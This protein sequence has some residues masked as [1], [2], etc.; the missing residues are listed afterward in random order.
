MAKTLQFRRGTTAELSSVTGAEGEL[1]V[2]TT[3]DTV[4]VMDG[5]T[6]GG[7]PLAT[8]SY[9]GTAISNLIDAAP[10]ALDT[11]NELAAALGDDANF[12]TTITNA[13]TTAGSYANSAYGQANTATTDAAAA[14]SYAN[15]AYSKANTAQIHA[16]AAFDAAN[17]GGGGGGGA[18]TGDFT[19]SANTITLPDYTD[20]TINVHGNTTTTITT[21]TPVTYTQ[22]EGNWDGMIDVTWDM[23]SLYY[24]ASSGSAFGQQLRDNIPS[25]TSI[26]LQNGAGSQ[27]LTTTTDFSYDSMSM[28]WTATVASSTMMMTNYTSMTFDVESSEEVTSNQDFTYTFS[29]SGE[30]ISD[31]ALLGTI[32]ISDNILSALPLISDDSYQT[33]TPQPVIINGDFEVLGN[34]TGDFTVTGLF[35]SNQSAEGYVNITTTASGT[36]GIPLDFNSGAIFYSRLRDSSFDSINF[37]NIPRVTGQV[38]TVTLI[39]DQNTAYMPTNFYIDNNSVTPYW[40]GGSA[41][42]GTD[43]TIDVLSFTIMWISGTSYTVLASATN[44]AAA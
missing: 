13:S 7:K 8:E 34:V 35:K 16:Q 44:Y 20:A 36:Y 27:T 22:G 3:K 30:F 42:S 15:S 2:D 21:S 19:F 17:T 14:G 40:L 12:A 32:L 18:S 25:G 5:S 43:D 10:G 41:P 1:F 33:E 31:S 38:V 23:T 11:L 4:V 26:T 37:K 28:R 9:V 24:S 39:L 29:S 6:A